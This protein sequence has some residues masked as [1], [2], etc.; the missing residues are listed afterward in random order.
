MDSR[1]E[2]FEQETMNQCIELMNDYI[3][4]NT[5]ELASKE[6]LREDMRIIS[7]YIYHF[8]HLPVDVDA[9]F[10]KKNLL[11]VDIISLPLIEEMIGDVKNFPVMIKNIK[12]IIAKRNRN[13]GFY[14]KLDDVISM[15]CTSLH[16]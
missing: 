3:C 6:S 2:S 9:V 11:S 7:Q 13:D 10:S 12:L 4:K 16:R 15:H 8:S 5:D 14:K 1:H